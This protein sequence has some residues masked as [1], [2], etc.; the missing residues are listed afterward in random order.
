MRTEDR[1]LFDTW[2]KAW[3]DLGHF[4]V[5][6]VRTSAEAARHIADRL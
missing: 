5:V 1:S 6:P 2:A 3:S 4:E